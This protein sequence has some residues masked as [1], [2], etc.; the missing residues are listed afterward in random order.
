[1]GSILSVN[2][3]HKEIFVSCY[4]LTPPFLTIQTALYNTYMYFACIV[5]V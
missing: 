1:M 4:I 5:N 2:I 3:L